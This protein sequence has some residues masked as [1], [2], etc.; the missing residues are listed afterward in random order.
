MTILQLRI[1]TEV[2]FMIDLFFVPQIFFVRNDK[3]HRRFN[4]FIL[5]PQC[6]HT[7]TNKIFLKSLELNKRYKYMSKVVDWLATT[8]T[9]LP[10]PGLVTRVYETSAAR[11]TRAVKR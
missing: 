8:P 1:P 5:T 2:M 4:F 6:I 11:K 10:N 9:L 7:H 3:H